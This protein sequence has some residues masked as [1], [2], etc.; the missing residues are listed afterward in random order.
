MH[1]VLDQDYD[2]NEPLPLRVNV[3]WKAHNYG[4]LNFVNFSN[5]RLCCPVENNV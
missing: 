3:P 4:L 2:G 5:F 1:H